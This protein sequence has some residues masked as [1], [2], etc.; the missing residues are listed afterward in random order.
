MTE[1]F[2]IESIPFFDASSYCRHRSVRQ[3]NVP[4]PA[5]GSICSNVAW[6]ILFGCSVPSGSWSRDGNFSCTD[7]QSPRSGTYTGTV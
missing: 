7:S 5:D 4:S 1:L 2:R 6:K 3:C